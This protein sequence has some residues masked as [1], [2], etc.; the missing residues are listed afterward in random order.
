M[1][2]RWSCSPAASTP[3]PAR[4]RSCSIAAIASRSSAIGHRQSFAGCSRTWSGNWRRRSVGHPCSMS[5]SR[6][7][8][9]R[10]RIAKGVIEPAHSSS[11]RWQRLLRAPLAVTG[12]LSMRT[13][14]SASI[15]P[16]QLR[17]W[18][19]APH[20][21]LIRSRWKGSAACSRGCSRSGCAWTI[22]PSGG[23][24]RRSW[25]RS[26][27]SDLPTSS[28]THAVAPTFTT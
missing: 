26:R 21:P 22:R 1:P 11:P 7:S 19:P 4:W 27:G 28:A 25:N 12:S 9:Q 5:R 13:V 17:S 6:R 14:S 15:C 16:P 10:G 24:R 20:G 3:L 23:Q 2:R 18:E 8:W